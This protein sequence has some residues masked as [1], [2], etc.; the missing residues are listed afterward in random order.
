M[1]ASCNWVS[2]LISKRNWES[3]TSQGEAAEHAVS[4]FLLLDARAVVWASPA[5]TLES[6]FPKFP[7][8]M[9]LI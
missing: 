8:F 5:P 4:P 3:G 2:G 6:G 7:W 9:L 1:R